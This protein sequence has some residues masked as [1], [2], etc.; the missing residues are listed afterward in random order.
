SF[1]ILMSLLTL[2][3][4]RVPQLAPV[5]A[6]GLTRRRLGWLEL[7]RAVLL[8]GLVFVCAIPMG[9]GLAWVLLSVIN[10]E[11][12]GWKLPMYLFPFDYLRLGFYA[13]VAA[14][15]AAAWPA[16]RLMR[17]PPATLLRVFARER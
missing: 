7:L 5:W 8:A 11:A 10:V 12:F 14:F 2:A 13:M 4:L 16:L 17:T 15:L 3:D 9:L 6:L 1:A